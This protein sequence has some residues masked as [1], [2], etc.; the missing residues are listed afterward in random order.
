MDSAVPLIIVA[1]L[2]AASVLVRAPRPRAAA[3][4]GALEASI[5]RIG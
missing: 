5:G 3:M 4:L 1:L 2:A